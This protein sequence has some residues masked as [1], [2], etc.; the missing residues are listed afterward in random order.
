MPSMLFAFLF[1][2]DKLLIALF[3]S[4]PTL[5]TNLWERI[6]F[7]IEPALAAVSALLVVF[8][9]LVLALIRLFLSKTGKRGK[10]GP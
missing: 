6:R 2:F 8:S 7:E 3:I 10:V 1:S 4:P 9:L 5:P